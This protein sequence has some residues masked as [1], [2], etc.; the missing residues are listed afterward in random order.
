MKKRVL[1]TILLI[2]VLVFYLLFRYHSQKILNVANCIFESYSDNNHFYSPKSF[3]WTAS[4]RK[5]WSNILLEYD[6]Y[7]IKHQIPLFKNLNKAVSHCDVMDK[8][9]TLHLRVFNIDTNNSQY[10]PLTMKLINQCQPKCT[11]AY[12]SLLE[13]GAQL[14]PHRGLYKGVLRYHLGLRIPRDWQNC[15]LVVNGEKV[16]WKEGE[17]IIFDDRFLHYVHNNT[18]EERLILFLDIQ[19]DFRNP[20]LNFVNDIIISCLRTNDV[21]H[22]TVNRINWYEKLRPSNEHSGQ[23]IELA[24]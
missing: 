9:K 19:R 15:Y 3:P 7:L 8:W 16:H 6:N 20:I 12:F 23:K 21:L 18:D 10:F 4:F 24:V 11:L 5:N 14:S 17:D 1:I 22:D 13:P 2:I